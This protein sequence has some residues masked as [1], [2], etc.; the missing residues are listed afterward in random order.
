MRIFGVVLKIL[1]QKNVLAAKKRATISA[2]IFFDFHDFFA[3]FCHFR[4]FFSRF[5][6]HF[7][8]LF[9]N[10]EHESSFESS[11]FSA[12]MQIRGRKMS[13]GFTLNKEK[14]GKDRVMSFPLIL[15]LY[16][17]RTALCYAL[18]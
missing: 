13:P 17:K 15:P 3:I 8:E 11:R 4:E 12:G 9:C 1:R 14:V 18:M 6:C 5:F 16:T 2:I 7:R 10:F